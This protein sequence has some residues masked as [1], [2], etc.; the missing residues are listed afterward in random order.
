MD[1]YYQKLVYGALL[2]DIGKLVQRA[3]PGEGSH[4]DRG[5]VFFRKHFPGDEWQDVEDCICFHH[6]EA[7]RNAQLNNNSPAYIVYEADNIAAGAD[8]RRRDAAGSHGLF[9]RDM[10]LYSVFNV[11]RPEMVAEETVFRLE[12]M[13]ESGRINFPE[14]ASSVEISPLKYSYLLQAFEKGFRE[15]QA[16]SDSLESL[17]KLL[18]ACLVNVPSS[19][20]SAETADISLYNHSKITAMVAGCLYYYLLEKGVGNYREACFTQPEKLR[21]EKAMLL[22]S[23][24]V[25]GIQKFI[26]T[27][28][29]K[30]ALKSLRGRSFYL[31]IFL[32]HVIDEILE[33]CGLCR[34]NLLYSGG[35]HFYMV[36]P[37][38]ERVRAVLE[39]AK[40]RVNDWLMDTYSTDLYLALSFVEA[41]A[42]ELANGLDREQKTG[43]ML[44]ELFHRVSKSNSL[45]K[46]QRYSPRQLAELIEPGSAVN[47]SLEDG[48][49]CAVC[50]SSRFRLEPWENSMICPNC[51]ALFKAGD[52]LARVARRAGDRIEERPVIVVRQDNL[53]G[54]NFT[55]MSGTDHVGGDADD[56][57][58][59][60]TVA[61]NDA[62]CAKD[63]LFLPSVRDG[64]VC[65]SFT[66][67]G[68]A[69]K[70]L[71]QGQARRV[72]SVN[73]LLT[74]QN[75]M[76]NLWAGTYNVAGDGEG[77]VDFATLAQRSYGIRRVGVLRADVDNLG[78][79]FMNG[80]VMPA[81]TT[82]DGWDQS[83]AERFRYVS[84]SRSATLSYSLSMFFKHEINK[85]CQGRTEPITPFKIQGCNKKEGAERNVVIVYAGGDDVFIVGAWDEVIELAVDLNEAFRKFTNG[86]MTI[87]AGVGIFHSSFPVNRMAELTGELEQA[88]KAA[89]KNR[90]ALFGQEMEYLEDE[91]G[92]K[93]AKP[94][95]RHVYLWDDFR[96]GVCDE[97]LAGLLRWFNISD[98][99]DAQKDPGKLECGMSRL[100]KLL[101]LFRGMEDG[102]KKKS[103]WNWPG[104]PISWAGWNRRGRTGS[105]SAGFTGR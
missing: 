32:E 83:R 2:H 104:W 64:R 88:A 24:D 67:L 26:Y 97:K 61:P 69:E 6:A 45:N 41:S 74:G 103:G 57:G 9:R 84:L 68:T 56:R 77:L 65:L 13:A 63:I 94:V 66:D 5:A 1:A 71:Q 3:D 81:G 16:A 38:T 17:L 34:A 47:G 25:S 11:F 73:S 40:E 55:S 105:G 48:R 37:N 23:G 59:A 18:E 36:L 99:R 15:L 80:F 27:V 46:L 82:E 20:N 54:S 72:Y 95:F 49:E 43:N 50:G 60:G 79:A 10:P 93:L 62:V 31:E 12:T 89:G 70:L 39:T 76:T 96:R 44:G 28:S 87:S 21:Q 86:K 91:Q 92:N 100:Y 30:G 29:S 14:K 19:T 51:L 101:T 98:N 53:S 35:G 78:A 33:S 8:R 102:W 7:L 4:G 58:T 22:V 90:I 42:G 85:L 75:Y 52:K